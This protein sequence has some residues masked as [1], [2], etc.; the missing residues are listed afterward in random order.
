MK[1]INMKKGK[2]LLCALAA[3]LVFSLFSPAAAFAAEGGAAPVSAGAGSGS[4]SVKAGQSFT[5][6]QGAEVSADA[7]KVSYELT[8]SV[9]P[10]TDSVV[11]TDQQYSLVCTG[12]DGQSSTLPGSS[13]A[14][15]VMDGD[16]SATLTATFQHAGVYKF[17]LKPV[18]TDA[19]GYTYDETSYTLRFYVK[20][21][22][23]GLETV[24]YAQKG[25]DEKKVD[26]ISFRHSY[27]PE[28]KPTPAPTPLP[29]PKQTTVTRTTTTTTVVNR[30]VPVPKTGDDSQAA[31]Y[32]LL[33]GASAAALAVLLV[34]RAK[35]AD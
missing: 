8:Q 12:S 1:R 2:R 5:V 34:F 19:K 32:L 6:P 26:Q 20:N 33:L 30:T 27:T 17:I 18:V 11:Q 23:D 7:L 21:K 22:G 24:L 29:T 31:M 4:I 13:P 10:D 3:V 14:K 35:R 16:G 15:F 25:A 28:V 9:E